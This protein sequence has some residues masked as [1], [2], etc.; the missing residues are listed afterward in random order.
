MTDLEN[1]VVRVNSFY[2][3]KSFIPSS[4]ISD[5]YYISFI[6]SPLISEIICLLVIVLEVSYWWL[7]V[8]IKNTHIYCVVSQALDCSQWNEG[9]IE[10]ATS[11]AGI[12]ECTRVTA[13]GGG[14]GWERGVELGA[15][16]GGN[17]KTFWSLSDLGRA[18]LWPR[19][20]SYHRGHRPNTESNAGVFSWILSLIR[21]RAVVPHSA[22]VSSRGMIPGSA[23]LLRHKWSLWHVMSF[24]DDVGLLWVLH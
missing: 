19:W 15:W 10:C 5:Y 24:C 11:V 17:L 3:C 1:S 8:K 12:N 2:Y 7:I 14:E 4:L 23:L 20:V 9:K 18:R 21:N 6:S 13:G 16:G 22:N